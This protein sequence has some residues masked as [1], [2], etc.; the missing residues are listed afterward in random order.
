[1]YPAMHK[2]TTP[3]P[4]LNR[5]PDWFIAISLSLSLSSLSVWAHT[6]EHKSRERNKRCVLNEWRLKVVVFRCPQCQMLK[7]RKRKRLPLLPVLTSPSSPFLNSLFHLSF[8]LLTVIF[9][10]KK[11]FC[12]FL[13]NLISGFC[14][15]CNDTVIFW[16]K[17]YLFSR[18]S[19]N[20]HTGRP[21]SLRASCDLTGFRCSHGLFIGFFGTC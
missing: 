2:A 16:I 20:T 19:V 17:K 15:K 1:M 8:Y 18:G 14:Y 12:V 13:S 4:A 9:F 6:Q 5:T 3:K 7:D 11:K 10:K 21:S